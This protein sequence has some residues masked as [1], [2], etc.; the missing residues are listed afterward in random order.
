MEIGMNIPK[1]FGGGQ[2]FPDP[3]EGLGLHA[4]IRGDVILWKSLLKVRIGSNKL[5]IPLFRPM[6]IK[7]GDLPEGFYKD[8]LTDKSSELLPFFNLLIQHLEIGIGNH[9]QFSVFNKPDIL[10]G[11]G[12][13]QEAFIIANKIILFAEAIVQ[14]FSVIIDKIPDDPFF[15]ESNLFANLCFLEEKISP[16][17]FFL[18]KKPGKEF[19]FGIADMDDP[20]KSA[21]QI[22]KHNCPLWLQ[23]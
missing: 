17:I 13:V 12:M 7:G 21:D 9:K 8:L 2:S 20:F 15:N 5:E 4:D 11:R 18:R 14:F 23:K 3:A 6:G 22:I 10:V 16:G 19:F 1:L